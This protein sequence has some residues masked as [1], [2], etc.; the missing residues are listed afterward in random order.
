MKIINI[1]GGLGN[2]MFQY[3]FLLAMREATGDECLMDTSKYAT[4]KLHNGFELAEVFNI[5]ARSATKEE[6]KRVTR[7]T[8]NYKLSRVFRK[9]LP[10]KRT[11]VVEETPSCR[12]MPNVFAEAKGDLFY[13]GIW[14]NEKYF[15]HV[16]PLILKEFTYKNRL[17]EVNALATQKFSEKRTV[18]IH[19][20]RGDYLKHKIYLGL[21]GLDYYTTAIHYVKRKYGTGLH[22]AIFSNDMAWCRKHLL[23]LINECEHTLVDWNKGAESYNDIRLMSAC[24]VNI[25][26]NSS[27]SWWAAY[28]NEHL[29]KEVIAPK[30][31]INMPIEFC[32]QLPNW[33]LF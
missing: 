30:T 8:T 32:I 5:S 21:C 12:Y 26:A 4:Y 22:F 24:S 20:R 33:T 17:S 27:F 15:G 2:Q 19:V 18:S 3:A 1:S 23:P 29:E 11:E 16:R 31:W 9:F 14:Q 7:Y 10:K 13:E 25:I 28:L 6:L